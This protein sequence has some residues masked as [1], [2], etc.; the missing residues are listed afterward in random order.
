MSKSAS[1]TGRCLCGKV[2][3]AGGGEPSA[4]HACHCKDCQRFV[5]S[6]F[7][8]VN[9][10]TLEIN[11]PVHWFTSSDWGERGS[12]RRCG[13]ALFWRL[14]NG[15]GPKVVSIGSLDDPSS[16]GEIDEHYF[17]DLRPSAYDF[18]GS[19]KRLSREETLARFA[20]VTN[21]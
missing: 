2:T 19:A 7:I 20:G 4:A 14:R 8:G 6:A 5:G 21:D 16:I 18:S 13:S 11:G 3:Y 1:M 12:C 17:A 10:D 15:E 9:F